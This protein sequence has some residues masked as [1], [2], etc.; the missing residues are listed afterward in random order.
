MLRRIERTADLKLPRTPFDINFNVWR[1]LL[2]TCVYTRKSTVFLWSV[3]TASLRRLEGVAGLCLVCRAMRM[4]RGFELDHCLEGP[5]TNARLLMLARPPSSTVLA[6]RNVSGGPRPT[7][8]M[9]AKMK[10][11]R[12]RAILQTLPE[13]L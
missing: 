7:A 11:S 12:G 8:Y 4:R 13:L 6:A 10:K 9:V 5:A 2:P 3:C 1:G